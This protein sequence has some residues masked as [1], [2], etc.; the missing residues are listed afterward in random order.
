MSKNSLFTTEFVCEI[1][2]LEK[3]RKIT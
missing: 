1:Y 3:M 2:G